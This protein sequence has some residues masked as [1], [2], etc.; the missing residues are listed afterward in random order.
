MSAASPLASELAQESVAVSFDLP[1]LKKI[2]GAL[3]IAWALG[4]S[5][6][7]AWTWL[8]KLLGDLTD[9]E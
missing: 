6:G 8:R 7:F 3:F 2:T 5:A 4:F 1:T 9:P